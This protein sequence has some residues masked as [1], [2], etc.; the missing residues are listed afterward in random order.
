MIN[1][2]MRCFQ[3]GSFF[4]A[5]H[6]FY[7]SL[8]RYIKHEL[9]LCWTSNNESWKWLLLSPEWFSAVCDLSKKRLADSHYALLLSVLTLNQ[10]CHKCKKILLIIQFLF[11]FSPPLKMVFKPIYFLYPFFNFLCGFM[12]LKASQ[13]MV[14]LTQWF[15]IIFTGLEPFKFFHVTTCPGMVRDKLFLFVCPH[16]AFPSLMYSINFLSFYRTAPLTLYSVHR[17]ALKWL[18]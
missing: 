13:L 9:H 11:F 4:C 3:P 6:Y 15:T 2:K 5:N 1:Q 14:R 18:L 16:N 17:R 8:N 7:T 10:I 12:Y